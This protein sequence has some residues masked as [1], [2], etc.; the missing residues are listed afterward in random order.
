MA[1]FHSESIIES[2]EEFWNTEM[3][4]PFDDKKLDILTAGLNNM[5]S[6]AKCAKD[7]IFDKKPLKSYLT[8]QRLVK[9]L[10]FVLKGAQSL[11]KKSGLSKEFPHH[12]SNAIEGFKNVLDGLTQKVI[13]EDTNK[14]PNSSAIE[15][16]LELFYKAISKKP[17]NICT[18][19][20]AL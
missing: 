6:I 13:V 1:G 11:E 17:E 14:I 2:V 5:C 12:V 8:C 4:D 15:L 10:D 18:Y 19:S 9:V 7:L 16:L 20:A 3:D